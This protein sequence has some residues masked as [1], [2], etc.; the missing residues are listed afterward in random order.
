MR[1]CLRKSDNYL[2]EMQS[3]ATPGTLIQN[4]I[5]AGYTE[6]DIEEREV[7]PEEWQAILATQQPPPPGPPSERERIDALELAMLAMMDFSL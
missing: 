7:T 5:I 4:A 6:T 2:I 3:D 1:V